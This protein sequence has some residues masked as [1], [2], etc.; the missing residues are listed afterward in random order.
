[1]LSQN[2]GEVPKYP[3]RRK[4]VLDVREIS[5]RTSCSTWVRAV[6]YYVLA[7]AGNAAVARAVLQLIRRG[8]E[9]RGRH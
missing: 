1:M 7:L 8:R 3:A 6:V 2:S 9:A 5:S 4:A